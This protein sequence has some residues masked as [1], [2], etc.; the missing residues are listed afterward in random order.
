VVVH[1]GGNLM[2]H[3]NHFAGL[4]FGAAA[5]ISCHSEVLAQVCDVPPEDCRQDCE[6]RMLF[7]P[8]VGHGYVIEPQY[9]PRS[10]LQRRLMMLIK[11][12]AAEVACYGGFTEG[13][14]KPIGLGDMSDALGRTPRWPNTPDVPLQKR[15]TLRH[16]PG[17]HVH[18]LDIDV[19]YYQLRGNN[20]FLRE[21]CPHILRGRDVKHCVGSP[22]NYNLDRS[23]TALFIAT[24]LRSNLVT[25]V[26]VDGII[27]P[28]LIKEIQDFNYCWACAPNWR[29]KIA[30]ET[31]D[32][33]PGKRGHGWRYNHYHH[34]HVSIIPR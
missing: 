11:H 32:P 21:V 14:G 1:K 5:L 16:P 29:N 19:A 28:I 2:K 34:F 8:S 23:R 18:G 24:V 31:R 13:N 17:S 7:Q 20:N 25:A 22:D 27:A 10:Y 30:F 15:G 6:H 33:P 4:L 3:C 12:A 9:R 26:G